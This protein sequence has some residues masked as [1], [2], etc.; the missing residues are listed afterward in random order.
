MPGSIQP[1]LFG[2]YDH[3]QQEAERWRQ[4]A[5]CPACGTEERS[6]YMLRQNHG[7]EPGQSGICGFPPGGH[8][9]YAA[10]CTAQ[11]LVTNHITYATRK[12][13][14]EQ[15]ARDKARGREL[16]LDVDAIDAAARE[17]LRRTR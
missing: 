14:T 9:V 3:A 6:G 4:P 17:E 16:G 7:A 13:N 1:D 11:Y 12:D 15:L 8:P 2:D 10:M 5:T